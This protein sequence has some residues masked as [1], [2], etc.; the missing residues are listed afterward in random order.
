M[1]SPV[2]SPLDKYDRKKRDN[3]NSFDKLDFLMIVPIDQHVDKHK[4]I[5]EIV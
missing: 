1:K 5:S 2:R 3:P 4:H